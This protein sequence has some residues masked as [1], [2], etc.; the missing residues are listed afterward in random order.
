MSRSY[1][2]VRKFGEHDYT[3]FK[4]LANRRVRHN[5]DISSGKAYKKLLT[6]W[7]VY[8]INKFFTYLEFEHYHLFFNNYSLKEIKQKWDKGARK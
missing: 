2:R 6:T 7:D 8:Y 4:K 3:F 1:R 5:K